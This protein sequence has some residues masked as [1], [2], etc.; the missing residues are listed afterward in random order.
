MFVKTKRTCSKHRRNSIGWSK[1]TERSLSI[2]EYEESRPPRRNRRQ[3]L[4]PQD[5][6]HEMLTNEWSYSFKSLHSA[7]AEVRKERERRLKSHRAFQAWTH[8]REIVKMTKIK[9]FCRPV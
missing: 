8:F 1:L 4:I 3:I 9:I 6:R 5:V 7:I 2:D